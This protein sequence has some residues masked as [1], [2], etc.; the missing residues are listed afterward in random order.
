MRGG[1]KEPVRVKVLHPGMIGA[2]LAAFADHADH[3]MLLQVDVL[4]GEV[5]QL[6]DPQAAVEQQARH[7]VVASVDGIGAFGDFQQ[8]PDLVVG[9]HVDRVRLRLG[10]LEV[11]HRADVDVALG[12]GPAHEP[13]H[14][15]V[16]SEDR[17]G[18]Q[19]GV[20]QVA[21]P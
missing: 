21:Q 6:G 19:P 13:S 5:R 9:Q 1:V 12:D 15:L 18:L 17:L 4:D 8:S 2:D 20:G 10:L 7:G 3:V 14:P 11:G 16:A